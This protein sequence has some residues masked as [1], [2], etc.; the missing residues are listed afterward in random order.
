MAQPTDPSVITCRGALG[1]TLDFDRD[2]DKLFVYLKGLP[3]VIRRFS[4]ARD[5]RQNAS[6]FAFAY[7]IRGGQ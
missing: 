1:Q 4:A 2:V 6:I 7:A 5:Q 3:V